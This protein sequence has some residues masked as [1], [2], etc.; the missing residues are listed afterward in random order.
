MSNCQCYNPV[1]SLISELYHTLLKVSLHI[2]NQIINVVYIYV[3]D[4]C[5]SFL[6]KKELS[7]TLW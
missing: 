6:L 3:I 2:H 4:N 7:N 1:T 5:R